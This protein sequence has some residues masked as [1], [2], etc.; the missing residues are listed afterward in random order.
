MSTPD[1]P[2][3]HTHHLDRLLMQ[4]LR[5]FLGEVEAQALELLLHHLEW[6]ELSGG[7]PLM[8]QG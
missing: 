8:N 6:V 7:Q 4:H 2:A 5:N 1:S 3:A